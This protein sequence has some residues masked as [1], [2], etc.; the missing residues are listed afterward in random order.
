[1]TVWLDEQWELRQLAPEQ[2]IDRLT[3]A[4]E[5]AVGGPPD[6]R[7]DT[8]VDRVDR[9][10]TD[11]KLDGRTACQALNDLVD[12]VGKPPLR[13]R[14]RRR[15]GQL[16]KTIEAAAFALTAEY[17]Q[18]LAELAV[19]F[20]ELPRHRLAA[21]EEAVHQITERLRRTVE[22]YDALAKSLTKEAAELYTKL[23]PTIGTLE[24]VVGA[25]SG[26]PW[27][28]RSST[29]S[30]HSRRSATRRWWPVRC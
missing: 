5:A 18:K 1:M 29:C 15:P 19:H 12:L 14:R 2:L 7:F 22:T 28:P 8:I 10:R 26:R 25:A 9:T 30:A 27:R 3:A 24:S 23:L 17:E 20:I 21:A 16:Q 11:A 6:D 4:A 13:P